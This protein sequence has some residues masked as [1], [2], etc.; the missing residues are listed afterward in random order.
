[1]VQLTTAKL[2]DDAVTTAKL[3]AENL[4]RSVLL[5]GSMVLD[6]RVVS[7]LNATGF[8]C[9]RWQLTKQNFDQLVLDCEQTNSVSPTDEGFKSA[10]KVEVT[11]ADTNFLMSC[12]M[13]DRRWKKV[14]QHLKYGTS[15]AESLTLSFWVRSSL[16]GK[17]SVLFY[18]DDV[19]KA[20]FKV[21]RLTWFC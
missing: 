1:M 4:G 17:Y 12:C 10:I 11:T 18:Q 2:A 20:I 9:D 5:N 8:I 7:N 13:L 3:Y 16:V 6:Q 19:N 14:I 21:I 15:N